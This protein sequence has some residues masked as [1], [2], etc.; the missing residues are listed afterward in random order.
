MRNHRALIY[1]RKYLL[2]VYQVAG[3]RVLSRLGV[4]TPSGPIVDAGARFL[5]PPPAHPFAP[6]A[7]RRAPRT[8][9]PRRS[10]C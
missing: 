5:S 6:R 2:V 8:P 1:Y 4:A 7:C 10:A 9:A 3:R